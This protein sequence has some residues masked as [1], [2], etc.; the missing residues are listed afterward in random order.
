M[1]KYVCIL[2]IVT[3]TILATL[4][5][6]LVFAPSP[7][8]YI[9]NSQLGAVTQ[10]QQRSSRLNELTDKLVR[11]K[12]LSSEEAAEFELLHYE[13]RQVSRIAESGA[14]RSKGNYPENNLTATELDE[15]LGLS[16]QVV[17]EGDHSLTP[18]ERKR[19]LSLVEKSVTP[20]KQ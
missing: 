1:N 15:Y 9:E 11:D 2:A 12:K 14:P 20:Q 18:T 10:N 19:Y 6:V 17:S 13:E 7:T 3:T 8:I 5:A 4:V 16:R